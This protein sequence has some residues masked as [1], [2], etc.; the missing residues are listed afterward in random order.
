MA[1]YPLNQPIRLSTTVKDV[2]G[3]LVNATALTLTV[4]YANAD[5]TTDHRRQPLH[6]RR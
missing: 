1:R 4:K 2:T 5:G 6:T 3:T